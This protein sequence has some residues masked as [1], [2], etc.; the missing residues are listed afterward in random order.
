MPNNLRPLRRYLPMAHGNRLS[1]STARAYLSCR[2]PGIN[3]PTHDRSS[4]KAL[5]TAPQTASAPR[6][7]SSRPQPPTFHRPPY[8]HQI[9]QVSSWGRHVVVE[10]APESTE[11][12]E[13]GAEPSA[14]TSRPSNPSST[15]TPTPR[16]LEESSLSSTPSAPTILSTSA[17]Q[18]ASLSSQ[19]P[20]TTPSTTAPSPSTTAPSG[21]QPLAIP[22]H[23]SHGESAIFT[24]LSTALSPTTLT[25]QD[26]SG[27]CG[28]MYAIAIASE[29]FRGVSV[30]RQHRMVNEALKEEIK[31][32]HGLQ[33]KTAVPDGGS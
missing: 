31:G 6:A 21:A 30:V 33:V 29:R 28:S 19:P 17:A 9:R 4:G 27:G 7:P 18:S 32:L 20:S 1:V 5:H 26:I 25:V 2:P 12:T 10:P 15:A 8:R 24:S 16:A 14:P 23:L 22:P 13:S 11:S 3:E